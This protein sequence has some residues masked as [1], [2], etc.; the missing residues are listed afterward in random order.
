M[1]NPFDQFDSPQAGPSVVFPAPP[2]EPKTPK[3]TYRILSMAEKQQMGLDPTGDYQVSSE[4]QVAAVTQPRN[5]SNKISPQTRE[6]AIG[7]Y[8]AARQL[9]GIVAD[10]QKK[11]QSGPGATSGVSGL[12]DYLP[13]TANKRFDA[14]G[15]AA[16]GIVGKALGFTGGQLNTAAEAEMAVG[17]YLPQAGDRDDVILDKINR[18]SQ[19]ADVAE[20]RS[21]EM[22][23]GVPDANGNIRPADVEQ[24]PQYEI[25]NTGTRDTPDPLTAQQIDQMIRA[26]RP[27]EEIAAFAASKG[28]SAPSNLDAARAYLEQ[29]PRYQGGFTNAVDRKPVQENPFV[30]VLGGP[31]SGVGAYG[32][33]AA[34]AL[35]GGTLDELAGG[36][37]QQAKDLLAQQRPGATLAGNITGS[38]L[39]M[40]GVNGGLRLAGGRLAPLATRGGGIG[41]DMLYGAGFGAGESNDDRLTGAVEGGLAAGAGNFAGRGLVTGGG[42]LLSGVSSPAVQYLA[43]RGVRMTPGQIMG[44]GGMFGR[45]V[46]AVEDTLESVPFLGAAVKN[47]KVEGLKDFNREAF[48]DALAPIGQQ[49]EGTIGQDAIGEAQDLVSDAY[50]NAVGGKVMKLD[51]PFAKEAIDAYRIGRT[52]PTMGDQ[53]DYLVKNKISPLF[54]PGRR[55]DGPGFQAALQTTRK[56]AKD[57]SN[58]GA[59]GN[60]AAYYMRDL[61]DAFTGL[62]NRQAPEVMPGLNAANSAHK[63]VSI[64]GDAVNGAVNNSVESGLFSPAQ[65]GRFAVNNT[66]K[67]GGAR[68]AARGDVPF[69]EL[70]QAGQQVLPNAVPNS[71]TTDRALATLALPTA[72]GGAAAGSD[73]LNLPAPVTGSL[74]ALGLLS[75]RKGNDLFQALV[76]SRNPKIR[77]LGEEIIKQTRLGGMFG[78]AA[79]LPYAVNP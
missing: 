71:G 23:G 6:N 39:A 32:A 33:A 48:K 11:Y 78:G 61:G 64:L 22:L 43:N 46:R 18:L 13:T 38:A 35:T 29:N 50:G 54:L 2:K 47:R 19:L 8:N 7:G 10:L 41:G 26:G 57:F 70:Q 36:N 16:R 66:K 42:K 62:A 44:Q 79:A 28:F 75:T 73:Y 51:S 72:L 69:A 9:R 37:A 1:A 49:V 20:Q 53:F 21:V 56:A 77:Q 15:N 30:S 58:E 60:E 17:P 68:A 59:M 3:T 14:A 24:A 65:L 67:F 25:N 27:N 40:G 74:A 4:G 45:G 34:N 12:K 55:I 52:V 76:T 5:Q 31:N 63:N